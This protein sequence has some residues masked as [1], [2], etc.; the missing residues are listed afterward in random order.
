MNSNHWP[1]VT[2]ENPCPKCGKPDRCTMAPDGRAGHC[3]R[4]GETWR[5]GNASANGDG[6]RYL[7]AAHR[8]KPKAATTPAA[9]DRDW[10][11][12]AERLRGAMT[13]EHLAAL[14][15]AT[16]VP[17]AAWALLSPG[18][19]SAEDL[20]A[21][22]AG[23]AGWKEDPPG[24]AYAFAE[25]DGSGRVVGLSLRAPDGRKG[26]PARAKRGLV[27][28]VDLHQRADPVLIVEGASEVAACCAL[29][30]TAIGRPSNRA[31]SEDLAAMLDGRTVLVIGERDGKPGGAWPGRDGAK[32]VAQRL[33]GRW[34]E[35]VRWSLPPVDVK[36]MREWLRA[37]LAGGLKPHD[38]DAMRA[39][40]NEL[41]S[42][43]QSA[44]SRA[45]VM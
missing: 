7:G 25:H 41:M 21:M 29:G 44:A 13:E 6:T 10:K 38:A 11:A 5:D 43:L 45:C 22:H 15:E 9:N 34:S 20:R 4:G 40:G 37:K 16:G 36:D 3:F 31:G 18:W 28:P 33:A 8:T 2:H 19:A 42:A 35:P 17:A 24:G 32:A 1:K 12:E 39:A 26:S 23:G 30:L 27:V 14:S